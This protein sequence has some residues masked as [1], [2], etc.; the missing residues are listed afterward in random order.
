M[1]DDINSIVTHPFFST[2]TQQNT[3]EEND[4]IKAHLKNIGSTEPINTNKALNNS[5]TMSS[6]ELS[7]GTYDGEN[8]SQTAKA[9]FSLASLYFPEK[10]PEKDKLLAVGKRLKR[11]AQ[12]YFGQHVV[13]NIA[14]M[15]FK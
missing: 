13:P 6:F 5:I 11:A 14:T 8:K 3:T 12:T 7:I 1:V 10:L 9:W 2:H 15:T 4:P